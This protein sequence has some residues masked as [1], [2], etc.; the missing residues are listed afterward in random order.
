MT[1]RGERIEELKG[2]GDE[3]EGSIEGLLETIKI[4]KKRIE[5]LV[6]DKG[7][8]MKKTFG[9][10]I[11]SLLLAAPAFGGWPE[12]YQGDAFEEGQCLDFEA[13]II[14][15]EDHNPWGQ[16]SPVGVNA[17]GSL[18]MDDAV[19]HFAIHYLVNRKCEQPPWGTRDDEEVCEYRA[20]VRL[21]EPGR[22]LPW[23]D[24]SYIAY[25]HQPD[26][27]VP[28]ESVTWD[29][30]NEVGRFVDGVFDF[31]TPFWFYESD[32][33]TRT[34]WEFRPRKGELTFPKQRRG[35]QPRK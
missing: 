3:L 35:A 21:A 32:S 9:V 18:C 17:V 5:E 27:S 26:G 24:G 34:T 20:T 29:A 25:V 23:A 30:E 7:G 22:I 8:H 19:L 33:H 10:I 13:E 11:M 1:A 14:E 15:W 4:Y 2:E 31:V 6:K 16:R 28:Y 12:G